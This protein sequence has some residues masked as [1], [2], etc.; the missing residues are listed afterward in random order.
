MNLVMPR[1]WLSLLGAYTFLSYKK[2]LIYHMEALLQRISFCIS[3]WVW[4]ELGG[5]I[6]D[7]LQRHHQNIYNCS[8]LNNQVV[9]RVGKF[10]SRG[11]ISKWLNCKEGTT[12]KISYMGSFCDMW[13]STFPF[14]MNIQYHTSLLVIIF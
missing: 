12:E 5:V 10:A 1:R 8:F 6:L 7:F 9:Y 14:S 4:R 11:R 3:N 13:S 2:G